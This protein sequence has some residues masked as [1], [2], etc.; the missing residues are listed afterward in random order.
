MTGRI[1]GIAYD[2]INIPAHSS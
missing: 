1:T 2:I